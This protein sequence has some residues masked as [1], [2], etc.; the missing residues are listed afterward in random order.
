M[1]WLRHHHDDWRG[2]VRSGALAALLLASAGAA[3]AESS[4]T[5][6]TPPCQFEPIGTAAA[7]PA[8]DGRTF[9]L[10]DGREVR[11]AGIEVPPLTAARDGVTPSAAGQAARAALD[12][13][14][15]GRTL[16]LS[17]IGPDRDRYGRLYAF[18]AIAGADG[19]KTVQHA[20]IAQGY[21]RVSA[22]VGPIAC[23]KEILEL[24]RQARAAKLGLW[25]EPY[26]ELKQAADPGSILGDQ[27]R[28]AIVQGKVVSVRESGATIY[29]NFSRRWSTDFTVTILKRNA[30]RLTAAGLEPKKLAGQQIRIR[31]WVEAR[32]GP[33][34]EAVYPEQIEVAEAR[35]DKPE[36]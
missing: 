12:G 20:L 30:R 36:N 19:H 35:T 29:V 33:L 2:V 14:I 22:R 23:A 13:L 5:A 18:A 3:R 7:G 9:A 34:I 26:Y 28:F 11:L 25:R 24:E 1:I 16:T 31:G 4:A 27:G 15:A 21:A 10:A 17:R 8:S 6:A 32:G